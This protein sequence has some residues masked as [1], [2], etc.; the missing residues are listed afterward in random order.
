MPTLILK[1]LDLS[2][3]GL[4]S[5][6]VTDLVDHYKV[7]YFRKVY[8]VIKNKTNFCLNVISQTLSRFESSLVE[9]LDGCL[10]FL[11]LYKTFLAPYLCSH[12]S[13]CNILSF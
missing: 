12:Q 4:T 3:D 7:G 5:G 2:M 13:M 1:L 6:K 8:R 11:S 10:V 9:T